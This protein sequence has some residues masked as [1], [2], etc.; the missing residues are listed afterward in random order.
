MSICE[1]VPVAGEVTHSRLVRSAATLPQ[2][3]SPLHP[4]AEDH[5]G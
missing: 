4:L 2:V 3:N 1:E 5:K